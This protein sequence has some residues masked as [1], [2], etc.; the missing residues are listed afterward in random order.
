MIVLCKRLLAG[1]SVRC[2]NSKSHVQPPADPCFCLVQLS[3]LLC[4]AITVG[5][6][7]LMLVGTF[8]WAKQQRLMFVPMIAVTVP[9]VSGHQDL[10]NALCR[11]HGLK[12]LT[13]TWSVIQVHTA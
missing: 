8:A 1:H 3:W 7:L 4:A 2:T 10:C 9:L 5:L 12:N 13:V 11:L 6:A